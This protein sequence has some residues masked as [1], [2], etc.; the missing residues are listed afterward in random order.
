VTF[1]L[2]DLILIRRCGWLA[3]LPRCDQATNIEIL[4][5]RHQIAVLHRPV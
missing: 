4:V 5:V 1:G 2:L 3:L